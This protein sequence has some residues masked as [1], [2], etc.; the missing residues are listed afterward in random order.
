M[1]KIQFDAIG[2]AWQINSTNHISDD[3]KTKI[4]QR[5]EQFDHT[6]S[7]FRQ[8]SDV[9]Q[10][11]TIGKY[12]LPDDAAP[13]LIFYKKLY[14]ASGGLVTP[15]IGKTMEQ[16]GYDA[17]YSLKPKQ[18]TAPPNW[19][20]AIEITK[21]HI[22]V[23]Q[24]V[25]LDFGA[26]GKGYLVDIIT[27]LLYKNGLDEFCVNA[28]GD[29]YMRNLAQAVG[30]EDPDDQT[31]MLG[32]V[33]IVNGALCASAGNRRKWSTF[34]HIINPETLVSPDN[35]K[36]TWVTAEN[37]MLADG[38]ATALFFVKPEILQRTFEFEYAMIEGE[39]M[40]LSKNFRVKLFTEE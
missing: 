36:A 35:V 13:L 40:K 22:I 12:P 38:I 21:S 24:L 2:T 33:E 19:G 4:L 10:W 11:A 9:S 25:L 14:G 18:L 31:R 29:M 32:T 30:L 15:L 5:I 3:L 1:Q 37:T 16:A 26:A 17:E 23:K 6:Y 39:A 20:E 8:D 27:H 28:G 34:H 7:R